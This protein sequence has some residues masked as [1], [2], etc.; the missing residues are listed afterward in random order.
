MSRKSDIYHSILI[1][2]SSDHFNSKIKKYLTGFITIDIK[3]SV[4]IARRCILEKYYDIIVINA[5]LQDESGIEFAFDSIEKSNASVLFVS[6]IEVYEDVLENVTDKGILAIT[7]DMVDS[8]LDKAIRYLIAVQN[9][10]HR[11]EQKTLTLEEKMEEIRIVNRAKLILVE[12]RNM[13]EDEAH[14][15]IGKCAMDNGVSRRRIA[16]DIIN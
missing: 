4:S 8:R 5:P 16:E 14:A 3:K 15:Y 9:R 10:V 2:S 13:T 6:P 7:K 1:V 12:Q 11:L